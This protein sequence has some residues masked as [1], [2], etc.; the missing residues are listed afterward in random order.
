MLTV[1]FDRLRVGRRTRFIDVGAGAVEGAGHDRVQ[2][3]ELRVLERAHDALA[4]RLIRAVRVGVEGA[5]PEAGLAV[6]GE[7]V[8]GGDV[9]VLALH[10]LGRDDARADQACG[11]G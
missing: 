9:A 2:A 1:D 5:V 11:P 10:L 6:E 4:Y 8:L 7:L 3:L